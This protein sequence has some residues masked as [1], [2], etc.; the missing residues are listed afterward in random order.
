M[1]AEGYKAGG[2]LATASLSIPITND[3]APTTFSLTV[4]T[5]YIVSTFAGDGIGGYQDGIPGKFNYPVGLAFD[6]NGDLLV[7]EAGNH[8][9]RKIQPSGNVTTFIGD[10]VAGCIDG[11]GLAARVNAPHCFAID[12]AGNILMVDYW[13]Y[14]VRK[15][16]PSG[17]VSIFAGDGTSGY[18]D[19][20]GSSARFGIASEIS[21]APDG[22]FY[23]SDA[24]N[25][26]VRKMTSAGVV[27][28]FAGGTAAGFVDGNAQVA[29]FN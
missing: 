13:D 8:R 16:T 28:T 17:V 14:R 7:A 11:Q 6:G 21:I 3:T 22:N 25:Q 23:I 4:P 15:I 10:G 12:A 24:Q 29:R 27:T 9:A 2:C 20:T 18:L 19:G 5:P 26:C 1:E